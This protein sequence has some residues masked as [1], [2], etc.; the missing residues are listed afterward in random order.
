MVMN[1]FPSYD[2]LVIPYLKSIFGGAKSVVIF[3]DMRLAWVHK[4]TANRVGH[5]EIFSSCGQIWIENRSQPTPDRRKTQGKLMTGGYRLSIEETCVAIEIRLR[6]GRS[7]QFFIVTTA[8]ANEIWWGKWLV[9][10]LK[11]KSTSPIVF[12]IHF[13][14]QF[15]W[16]KLL[17]AV[18][19]ERLYG[20]C[21]YLNRRGKG[22]GQ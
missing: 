5:S 6:E 7:D 12:Q 19:R 3:Q 11:S 2:N 15:P 18:G 1:C 8:M 22:T 14:N 20:R 4:P 9:A 13:Q 21:N 10:H 16:V 17:G